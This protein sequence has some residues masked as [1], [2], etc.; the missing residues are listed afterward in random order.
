M[1]TLNKLKLKRGSIKGHITRLKSYFDT[2]D[3]NNVAELEVAQLRSRLDRAE[4]LLCQF[5]DI[6]NDIEVEL[7]AFDQ[8]GEVN[9][10]KI[11]EQQSQ[12]RLAFE[13]EFY[14]ITSKIKLVIN[15][16]ES[17]N[18]SNNSGKGAK[19]SSKASSVVANSA[20]R[21]VNTTIPTIVQT[22]NTQVNSQ[23]QPL[24]QALSQTP[25]F[26]KLP[27]LKLPMFNGAYEKWL[28]FRDS[29][30]AMIH[31][32]HNLSDVQRFYYLKSYLEAEPLQAIANL[33]VT[34]DNYSVAWDLL[35]DRYENK[36]LIIF[37][38]IKAIFEHPGLLKESHNDLRKLY[39]LF[40][41]NLRSLKSL[42]QNTDNW[43]TLI[44]YLITG[45]FDSVTRREWE[46]YPI[47]NELP[48]FSDVNA[49][50]KSKCEIL[51]KLESVNKDSKVVQ[52]F[53]NKVRCHHS[54]A[55]SQ[56]Q[57]KFSCY[58]CKKNHSIYKCIAFK[59]LDVNSRIKAINGMKMCANCFNPSHQNVENCPRSSN[60]HQCGLKHNTLLHLGA[61]PKVSN[62]QQ[63]GRSE[64]ADV[65][66]I[67][68]SSA[69][70]LVGHARSEG[71]TL[72]VLSTAK[73]KVFDCNG[74][75][76]VVR[77]LL[78]PGSQSN[79]ITES[80]VNK[81]G[82]EKRNVNYDVVGVGEAL[83]AT[84]NSKTNIKIMSNTSDFS[85]FISC[86]VVPKIT[87]FLPT[88]SF[89][90]SNWNL[91]KDLVLADDSFNIP[92]AVDMLL[93]VDIFYR[94]LLTE[95]IKMAG[96]PVVQKTKLGWVFG[97]Y[98]NKNFG[99]GNSSHETIVSCFATDTSNQAID[100]QLSKFWE[101]EDCPNTLSRKYSD[102]EQFC[103]NHF[104]QNYSRNL[105]GR[106]IVK[107]PFKENVSE[108]GTSKDMAAKRLHFLMQRLNKNEVL[109]KEYIDFLTE[110]R[111]LG[112]MVKVEDFSL[113]DTDSKLCYYLPHHAIFK[114]SSLTTKT[115]VVFDASAKTNSGLS[116]NDTQYVGPTIQNDL[117]SIILQFRIYPFV[118]NADISKMYRQILIHSDER[119]FQRILWRNPDSSDAN[120]ECY[121]LQTVTYG[122][123]SSPFLAVRCLKQLA[124]DFKNEYPQACETILN[125]F[126]LDD[127]LA[128]SFSSDELLQLQRDI[129]F[130]L[131]SGGFQLRKW[132]SNKPELLSEFHVDSELSSGILQIGEF[133]QN[134]TLGVLWNAYTDTIHFSI[135]PLPASGIFT[136]RIILSVTSQIFDPLGLLG[137]I[138]VVAKLILQSLWQERLSWDEPVPS[139]LSERWV[140]FC[141]D[142]QTLNK[143]KIPRFVLCDNIGKV[144]IFGFADASERAY[145][146][147]VY[148]VSST[149][150]G[151]VVSSLLMSKSRIAPIKT[152]S[153]PRLELCAALLIAKLMD[154]VKRSIKLKIDKCYYLTDSTIA[155][156]WIR[157][158]PSR[159]K[160]F[161]ANR[162]TEIQ[163][164]TSP[165]YWFH[166]KSGQNPAD[167]LSRGISAQQLL[168][169]ELW[170]KG[171]V[172]YF[173]SPNDLQNLSDVPEDIPE[174]RVVS[175]SSII[176]ET[177][178]FDFNKFS[179]LLKLQR[180]FA[181]V[182]RFI[183]ILKNKTKFC[184][185]LTC[186][187][188][189]L[190]LQHLVKIA[191]KQS[192]PNEYGLFLNQ[193][194]IKTS[195]KLL[196]LNP[197][198]DSDG[199]IRVG[200]RIQKA[201]VSDEQ[202][203]PVILH[204]KHFLTILIMRH[205]HEILLHCGPQQLLNSMR[206]QFWPISGR[207]LA[208]F[209]VRRCVICFK[210]KPITTDYLMGNLPECRVS[211]YQ[212]VF[213]HTGIDYA[214]PIEIRDR[215]TRN[216]K[217]LKAYICIFVCMTTKCIH[218]ECVTDL[219][220]QSFILVLRRFVARRGKPLHLYSDNGTNFVGANSIISQFFKSNSNEIA[221][222]L[223]NDGINWHF[224]PP[225]APNFGGLW[226]AGVKS[227]KFH[228]K[229]VVGEAKLTYEELSTVLTQIEGVLNSRP[230]SP[231]ST[232][233][234]DMTPLTPAHFLMGRPITSLPDN[235]YKQ[236]PEN[237]LAK[238]QRLQVMVQHFWE[239][240]N[241][242]YI[243]ELQS[244]VKWKRNHPSLLKLG[245]I[246]LI[247]EDNLPVSAWKLGRVMELH[248]GHDGIVRVASVKCKDN[249]QCK[250]AV[251]KLC[252]L[253]IGESDFTS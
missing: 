191:Q 150:D 226:E 223:S 241:K 224:I 169:F 42:G 131:E 104:M 239:R 101:L 235:D 133:E 232:D 105:K 112:H 98:Y 106:F 156:C 130:I 55:N 192:F 158:C 117:L 148:M 147:C 122:C 70:T 121:E 119:R 196:S 20:I 248:C 46:S 249:S 61:T 189:I 76:Y 89:N 12:E 218:L 43:D 214:G 65:C 197:Y 81:L 47:S 211:A 27:D 195:S 129:H 45:K 35:V 39:D 135:N 184:E 163:D 142:L 97:G 54:T 40:N 59:R 246:V 58:Y 230:L 103:E 188:L 219:T 9:I 86:L 125:C 172:S 240:W 77:A 175:H 213:S 15:D 72:S 212:P 174:Q 110:Y 84:V 210:A 14:S 10:E 145:G 92:G 247:K 237:R 242:E 57:G 251:T 159:W 199:L 177:P 203:H 222:T 190:S 146:G 23:L 62:S 115:R 6:Q 171:P 216:P 244:R 100:E 154:K 144:C 143:L 78:D 56:V 90:I 149:K 201:K 252:V 245:S 243:S 107:F 34:N 215:K 155:L 96:L 202:R 30:L 113:I 26:V 207:S 126:Y 60:C 29:F 127:L 25:I 166:I 111:E 176:M 238:F 102:S 170:W 4:A 41:K 33:S 114:E 139:F 183:K 32:N 50:L 236:M 234:E 71:T 5:E 75:E 160:T 186:S 19:T 68:S 206:Q 185:P 134:K 229:R 31:S 80:L 164:L 204:N 162:V 21:S 74:S 16:F 109:Q 217:F 63:H 95:Q 138:V 88:V 141:E 250:R 124:L 151:N 49:F 182:L 128:G 180:V 116:L 91:S 53:E 69:T 108:L 37:N 79:F 13:Q 120:T 152:I 157:G 231:L 11:L 168:N 181:Y 36:R 22:P 208:R 228:L 52:R 3:L 137:P 38:Y 161:V 73:I 1:S 194:S 167:C 82:L 205:T 67:P 85:E 136:K 118:I 165:E 7:G 198:L 140:N 209:I 17:C 87:Q 225:R 233:P 178:D 221:S 83:T 132:L 44:V 187:E 51:E 193:R 8:E 94:I 28:E 99:K 220:S 24:T 153:L 200:G 123:A 48:Q 18:A 253:P 2:L 173:L 64:T 227:V 179:H 93:G 66:P